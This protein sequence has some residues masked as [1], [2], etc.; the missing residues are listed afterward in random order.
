MF[1]WLEQEIAAVKTPGFHRVDG[2]ADGEMRELISAASDTIPADYKEFVLKFGGAKLY[3]SADELSYGVSVFGSPRQLKADGEVRR[4]GLGKH[5]GTFVYV[6][7]TPDPGA[8]AAFHGGAEGHAVDSFA[9]WL[10]RA[11]DFQREQYSAEEWQGVLR[12]E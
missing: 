1:E 11:C 2:P 12:G 3:R 7:A 6:E 5:A 10:R 4:F 8:V 9:E